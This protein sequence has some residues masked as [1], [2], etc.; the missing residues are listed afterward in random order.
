[1]REKR[2]SPAVMRGFS[3]ALPS[4]DLLSMDST[5]APCGQAGKEQESAPGGGRKGDGGGGRRGWGLGQLEL[6]AG[7]GG[8]VL[9]GDVDAEGLPGGQGCGEIEGDFLGG[10][11]D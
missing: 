3:S 1:M 5:R 6:A 11:D 2:E 8:L 7:V 4:A 9:G 10:I